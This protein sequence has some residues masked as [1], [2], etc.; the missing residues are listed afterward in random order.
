MRKKNL[1]VRISP[2]KCGN[3]NCIKVWEGEIWI[4]DSWTLNQS[5]I[6]KAIVGLISHETIEWV[7]EKITPL[8]DIHSLIGSH[9]KIEDYIGNT[10]GIVYPKKN[11]AYKQNRRSN[12]R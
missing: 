7:L 6:Q 11:G 9:Q 4:E 5:T 3:E 1:L 10:D 12:A 2:Y 8:E